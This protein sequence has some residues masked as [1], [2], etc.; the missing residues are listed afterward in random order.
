MW[1]GEMTLAA[2]VSFLYNGD[3]NPVSQGHGGYKALAAA[4]SADSSVVGFLLSG[5]QI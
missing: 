3:N 5:N 1:L 2:S 4:V